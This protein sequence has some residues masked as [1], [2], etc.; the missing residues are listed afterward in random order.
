[1]QHWQQ[2]LSQNC[3]NWEELWCTH[4]CQLTHSYVSNRS[5]MWSKDTKNTDILLFW[6]NFQT[7]STPNINLA[8][9]NLHTLSPAWYAIFHS[10][11]SR[12]CPCEAK[13][14]AISVHIIWENRILKFLSVRYT[15]TC[16]RCKKILC[17]AQLH[18]VQTPENLLL[19]LQTFAGFH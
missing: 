4:F 11:P 3:H 18:P 9:W 7:G 13:N 10:D 1:M 15:V 12:S 19:Q 2:C 17:S 14:S 5:F 16:G 8:K 6:S